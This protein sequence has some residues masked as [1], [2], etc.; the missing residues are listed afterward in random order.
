MKVYHVL[1][2]ILDD[3]YPEIFSS[4]ENCKN[5]DHTINRIVGKLIAHNNSW[6]K[7]EHIVIIP[8]KKF[9][10]KNGSILHKD[11]YK[12]IFSKTSQ[13]ISYP[14]EY[15]YELIQYIKNI[16]DGVIHIYGTGSFM[17]DFIAPYLKN[18]LSI[19]H[20]MWG[21]FTWKFFPISVIKYFIIQPI[22]LR[23]PKILFIQNK[24]RIEQY[25]K[26]YHIPKNKMI[27]VP[28]AIEMSDFSE[29][30]YIKKDKIILFFASRLE[31]AKWI[32]EVIAVFKILEKQYKNIELIIAWQG[33][34]LQRIQKDIE[35]SKNIHFVW[36]LWY[37]QMLEHLYK[38]DIF[39]LPTHFDCFPSALLEA[40][41]AWLPI[42]STQVEWPLSI[43]KEWETG[44]LIPVGDKNSLYSKLKLLIEN[45]E[46][47]EQFWKNGYLYIKNTFTWEKVA[48]LYFDIYRRLSNQK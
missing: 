39:V 14:F 40:S 22:T 47:R 11:G 10:L 29:K 46:I 31:K 8:S 18:K 38:S 34:Q 41:A 26:Y 16:D 33:S 45:G 44:F 23:F 20:Y 36:N 15:S 32:F 21:H 9:G 7:I 3:Y 30:K 17:Y 35:N 6:E 27:F 5:L 13:F 43:V 25:F 28:W 48:P 19:A 24:F 37:Q 4:I 12:I 42:I 2:H 1:S